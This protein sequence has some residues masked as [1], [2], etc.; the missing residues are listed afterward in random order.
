MSDSGNSPTT[1]RASFTFSKPDAKVN[2]PEESNAFIDQSSSNSSRR[3]KSKS[4]CC[5]TW[6]RCLTTVCI[7]VV[8]IVVVLLGLY[9][10]A[11][12]KLTGEASSENSK[13]W[14]DI[15]DSGANLDSNWQNK[16][17]FNGV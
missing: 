12:S 13:E 11:R 1:N 4:S 14:E 7:I 17:W 15:L 3:T 2:V 5:C 16:Y 8:A 10:G 6:K 9:F